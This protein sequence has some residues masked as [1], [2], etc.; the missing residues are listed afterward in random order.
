MPISSILLTVHGVETLGQWQEE[1]S[2]SFDGIDGLHHEPHK[3]G[4]FRVYK[5]LV[6]SYRKAQVRRF[7]ELYD[8]WCKDNTIRPSIIA[9][10]FG[11]Y[12]VAAALRRYPAMEFDSVILCGSI[13]A[14][15]YPWSKL[16]GEKVSRVRNELA[17]EDSV[18]KLFRSKLL[19]RLI[20]GTGTSGVDGFT[21]PPAEVSNEPSSYTHSEY[22]LIKKHCNRY[23]R[24][25]VRNV[26]AFTDVC[27][28][29][30]RRSDE[31][32]KKFN[33]LYA[34]IVHDVV[35]VVFPKQSDDWR[36]ALAGAV[37]AGVA[38]RG[39]EGIYDAEKLA[40]TLCIEIRETQRKLG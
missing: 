28:G 21:A 4:V 18:V 27:W 29:C 12:I 2:P 11:T 24:P 32:W 31:A 14:N 5:I 8:R 13:V 7:A 10:S 39:C 34:P 22:F 1:I 35:R 26:L 17:A 38:A 23:W 19:R 6:P 16:I 3:Y 25:F 37:I 15:D 30:S 9:H 20:P 36:N 33:V 40:L